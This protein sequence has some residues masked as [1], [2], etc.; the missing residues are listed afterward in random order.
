MIRVTS[1][2]KVLTVVFVWRRLNAGAGEDEA[3]LKTGPGLPKLTPCEELSLRVR[4]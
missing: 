4:W 3:V 2:G 1:P